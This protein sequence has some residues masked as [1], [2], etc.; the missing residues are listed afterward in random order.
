[1]ALS[2]K[3]PL[4]LSFP[5]HGMFLS[6]GIPPFCHIHRTT[7]PKYTHREGFTKEPFPPFRSHNNTV[8]APHTTFPHTG[9]QQKTHTDLSQK[10]SSHKTF[11]SHK[12]TVVKKTACLLQAVN[13]R[14]WSLDG[15]LVKQGDSRPTESQPNRVRRVPTLRDAHNTYTPQQATL[16]FFTT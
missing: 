3:S 13:A 16:V 10:L 15:R 7:T 11:V 1:M 2:E 6:A 14:G 4:P 8:G 9:F 5:Q 12:H